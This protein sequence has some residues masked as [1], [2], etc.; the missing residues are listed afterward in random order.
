MPTFQQ[1]TRGGGFITSE[2]NPARSRESIVVPGG[3]GF[4]RAGTVLG[5]ITA[6]GKYV[7]SPFPVGGDGSSLAT[8]IAFDDID[9]SGTDDVIGTAIVGAAE[10]RADDLIYDSSVVTLADQQAKWAQ[11]EARG[12][13]VRL[14]SDVRTQ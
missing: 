12:I 7:P 11:L 8:A 4:V 9:A 3:T 10:V 14:N 2:S 13:I 6:V 1:R 5:M